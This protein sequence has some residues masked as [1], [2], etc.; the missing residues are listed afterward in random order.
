V[1][2]GTKSGDRAS[3]ATGWLSFVFNATQLQLHLAIRKKKLERDNCKAPKK[4]FTFGA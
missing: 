4:Y 1:G 2:S 3:I